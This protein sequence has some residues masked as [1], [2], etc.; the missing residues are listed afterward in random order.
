ML[1]NPKESAHPIFPEQ[2]EY[3]L[4]RIV[5][6]SG[7]PV[8]DQD[9]TAEL[10]FRHKLTGNLKRLRFT[11]VRLSSVPF[12]YLRGYLPV[13]VATTTGRG[14]ESGTEIEV[15]D[16]DPGDVWFWASE[17]IDVSAVSDA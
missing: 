2:S 3:R 15:G 9:A 11:G 10:T 12:Q 1:S 5:L 4:D 14:W 13:Y 6:D 16:L 7:D 17:A 8:T